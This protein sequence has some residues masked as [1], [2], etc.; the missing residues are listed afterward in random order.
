MKGLRTAR[1]NNR[2]FI[3][4]SEY[5]YNNESNCYLPFILEDY[6]LNSM[7]C[8][9]VQT[10]TSHNFA[11]QLKLNRCSCNT[12]PQIKSQPNSWLT[13]KAIHH[14]WNDSDWSVGSTNNRVLTNEMV[15][16]GW[17]TCETTIEHAFLSINMQGRSQN[18][19]WK[20]LMLTD[21]WRLN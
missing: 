8:G 7:D 2:H 13:K 14:S 11:S 6:S 5:S 21:N 10:I 12:L 4:F 18:I 17:V 19:T 1:A 15:I 16:E 9:S 3:L 20:L